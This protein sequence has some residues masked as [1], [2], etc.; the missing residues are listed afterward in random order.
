MDATPAASALMFASNAMGGHST[1]RHLALLVVMAKQPGHSTRH[2]AAALGVTPPVISRA[3]DA[4]ETAQLATTSRDRI[5]ERRVIL[6]PT[7]KGTLVASS[8]SGL[9]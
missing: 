6:R 9:A 2:Y 3:M 4:L 5:D 7:R 8:F 1:I